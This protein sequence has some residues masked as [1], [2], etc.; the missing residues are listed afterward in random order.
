MSTRPSKD[1]YYIGIAK[2]VLERS[3]CLRRKYGAVLVKDDEIISTGYN[4]SPRGEKNCC[5]VGYC[6]RERQNIPKGERY[7]LCVS[8]HAEDNAITSASRS[9]ANGTYKKDLEDL[10]KC[11]LNFVGLT[12]IGPNECILGNIRDLVNSY[13]NGMCNDLESN[14]QMYKDSYGIDLEDTIDADRDKFTT[15]GTPY[16]IRSRQ[17][18]KSLFNN[19]FEI[20][21]KSERRYVNAISITDEIVTPSEIKIK[22]GFK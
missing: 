2:A 5:D 8:V 16:Y 18:K 21:R 7:E 14:I 15:R 9:R 10:S 1:E 12:Q 3:T 17:L 6:E 13:K 22:H 19:A 20:A 4:G 11:R